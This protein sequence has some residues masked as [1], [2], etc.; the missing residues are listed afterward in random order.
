[1]LILVDMRKPF[2]GAT[3]S[4]NIRLNTRGAARTLTM[5]IHGPVP[6]YLGKVMCVFVS[7]DK[8]ISKDF[9]AGIANQ[10]NIA[11]KQTLDS[12]VAEQSA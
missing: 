2:E 4:S 10:K 8:M 6:Y 5:A 11:E 9:G 7:M 1:V 3:I 12:I